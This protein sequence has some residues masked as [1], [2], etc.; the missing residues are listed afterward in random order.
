V[1][2]VQV[3]LVMV[4]PVALVVEVQDDL[5]HLAVQVQQAKVTVV[6]MLNQILMLNSPDQVVVEQVL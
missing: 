6:V 1:A 4:S 2:A 3:M 5:P